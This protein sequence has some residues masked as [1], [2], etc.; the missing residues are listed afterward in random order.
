MASNQTEYFRLEQK[1]LTE[2]L[3]AEKSKP[4]EIY[5]RMCDMYGEACFNEKICSNGLN[6]DLPQRARVKNTDD[7]METYWLSGK[8]EGSGLSNLW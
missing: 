7:G 6:T 5:K 1:S 8:V 3:V 2:I 4:C